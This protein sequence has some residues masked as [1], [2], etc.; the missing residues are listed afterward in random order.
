MDDETRQKHMKVLADYR[1]LV[2]GWP[3]KETIEE[4]IQAFKEAQEM[5]GRARIAEM[6]LSADLPR[7]TPTAEQRIQHLEEFCEWLG[8]DSAQIFKWMARRQYGG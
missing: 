5:E 7:K 4:R 6:L 3:L 2:D 8:V 1:N